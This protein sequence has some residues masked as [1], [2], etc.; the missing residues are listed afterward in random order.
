MFQ[1][2]A[3]S[4]DLWPGCTSR[5]MCYVYV[6]LL[7]VPVSAALSLSYISMSRFFGNVGRIVHK[8]DTNKS[9]VS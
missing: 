7:H 5:F 1:F 3:I 4:F 9:K 8:G 6:C 2:L